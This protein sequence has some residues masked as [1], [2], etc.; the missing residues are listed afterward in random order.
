[1]PLTLITNDNIED[2]S[3]QIPVLSGYTVLSTGNSLSALSGLDARLYTNSNNLST[4]KLSILQL[5]NSRAGITNFNGGLSYRFNQG[6]NS[7]VQDISGFRFKF[8]AGTM[9]P[10]KCSSFRDFYYANYDQFYTVPANVK[11]IF[12]KMWGAGGGAGR[13]GGWTHGSFGGG[14]GHSRGVIPV[15]PGETLRIVVGEGGRTVSTTGPRY[16][17]G[18]YQPN[19]AVDG[20]K[21][22][23]SGG[24]YAGIF[25]G[26]VTQGNALLVAGGGGGG[27]CGLDNNDWDGWAD[28]C[29]GGAGGGLEGCRGEITSYDRYD[30]GGTGGTQTAGGF[31]PSN[32]S[33]GVGSAFQGGNTI[34]ASYGGAGG[35]GY[36]GGGAG[37]YTAPPMP[38]GGGGSGYVHSSVIMGGTYAGCFWHPSF[39]WDPDLVVWVNSTYTKM[40][41]G[42]INTNN[43]QAADDFSG[44]HAYVAIWALESDV[45]KEISQPAIQKP[46]AITAFTSIGKNSW[47]HHTQV[48]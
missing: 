25:R 28:T 46:G 38:G 7:A 48:M 23:G 42:G 31:P 8:E 36:W 21:Y 16:G 40:A 30:D 47:W 34:G 41:Y 17:N 26:P 2:T 10:A 18:G 19:H 3:I 4:N 37:Y 14:G 43:N 13:A 11:Y 1:M 22:S 6:T 9:T 35:G 5:L 12:V 15:V 20:S 24:G 39:F 45:T 29:G 27:G 44:G 33:A 32:P